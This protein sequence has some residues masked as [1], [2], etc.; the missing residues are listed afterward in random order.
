M[1]KDTKTA[2]ERLLA[3]NETK[4]KCIEHNLM[5]DIATKIL[6][7]MLD[8]YH[9][10]GTTYI[11]K[12]LK[13]KGRYDVPR[14]YV[15]NLYNQRGKQDVVLIRVLDEDEKVLQS[16]AARRKTAEQNA[17]SVSSSWTRDSS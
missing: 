1:T 5:S 6:F 15:V 12:E 14:K 4:M 10:D 3:V 8:N 7:K 17:R 13:L 16:L 2:S 11:G 9:R